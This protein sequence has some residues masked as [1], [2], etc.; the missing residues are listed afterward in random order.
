MYFF[1]SS[2][3]S[4]F[5]SVCLSFPFSFFFLSHFPSFHHSFFLPVCISVF[6]PILF[7]FLFSFLIFFLSIILSICLSVRLSFF[8]SLCV[9][10]V[11][12]EWK[13]KREEEINLQIIKYLMFT[14]QTVEI[15]VQCLVYSNSTN[16]FKFQSE[17][18]PFVS[19]LHLFAWKKH[20]HFWSGT[21][22]INSV[23]YLN[24]L[25]YYLFILRVT[26]RIS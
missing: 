19:Q 15:Y 9:S 17:I 26:S 12:R 3:L 5:L 7:F 22:A 8:L 14:S 2:F 13:K 21:I 16:G 1:L 20:V 11:A 23:F 18:C 10:N 25:W 24:L 6:L 4:F